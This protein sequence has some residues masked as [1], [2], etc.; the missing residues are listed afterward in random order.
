MMVKNMFI[1]LYQD[2]VGDSEWQKNLEQRTWNPVST[3]QYSMGLGPK[4]DFRIEETAI[5]SGSMWVFTNFF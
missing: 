3:K 2:Q 1:L 5:E 4:E